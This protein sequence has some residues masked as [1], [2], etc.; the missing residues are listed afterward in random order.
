MPTSHKGWG[1]CSYAGSTNALTNLEFGI[2]VTQVYDDQDKA[3]SK[4]G[5]YS[6]DIENP[7]FIISLDMPA[8]L[9]H[10]ER[11]AVKLEVRFV[12]NRE[13]DESLEDLSGVSAMLSTKREKRLV[14]YQLRQLSNVQWSCLGRAETVKVRCTTHFKSGNCRQSKRSC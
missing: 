11:M 10:G 1:Q 8:A 13:A 2:K 9:R 7:L 6:A 5:L 12:K 4:A 14:R 3:R